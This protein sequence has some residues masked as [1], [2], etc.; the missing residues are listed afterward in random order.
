MKKKNPFLHSAVWL[1]AITIFAVC[2]FAGNTTLAMYR[3]E[4]TGAQTAGIAAFS[5]IVGGNEDGTLDDDAI[6]IAPTSV[7]DFGAALSLTILDTVDGNK[8]AHVADDMLAPGTY[9]EF[10]LPVYNKSDVDVKLT[11][12]VEATDPTGVTLPIQFYKGKD[13]ATAKA[14]P[15]LTS[16]APGDPIK[17]VNEVVLDKNGG[18]LS[19]ED[20]AGAD[21]NSYFWVWPYVAVSP[22]DDDDDTDIGVA[23]AAARDALVNPK[24]L[25][26][27]L[28]FTVTAEQ[29]D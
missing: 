13:L 26:Y 2:A 10:Q 19:E 9:G 11:I 3:A 21:T 16:A 14:S 22:R 5:I 24:L 23:A 6:D 7:T 8:D 1:L 15:A 20:V 28:T 18:K 29:I 25:E 27:T 4:A 17:L 12:E